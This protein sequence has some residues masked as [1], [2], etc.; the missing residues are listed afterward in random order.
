MTKVK[1][2]GLTNYEDAINAVN[3]GADYL[4]FNFYRRSPRRI[5]KIKAKK[6]I[7]NLPENA[8]SV[9]IF[10]NE[11]IGSIKSVIDFCKIGIVQL[12]GDEDAKF[13]S[14]IKKSAGIKVIK[15][16]RIR[17]RNDAK[18]TASFNAD[19]VMA[20]SFKKGFFGGTGTGLDLG[21]LEGINNKN[22]FLAGGLTAANVKSAASRIKPYA[23]DVCSS[24][25]KCPGKKDFEKMKE[26]I[27]A[28]K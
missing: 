21:F 5:E 14:N 2:C 3:L 12:S 15:S 24:I 10:A 28:A 16:F 6:I 8:I 25:E 11:R 23:V 17:S 4:G 26:F 9:G 1:I 18:N 7:E 22:L 19:Y 20:D 27:E 13:I